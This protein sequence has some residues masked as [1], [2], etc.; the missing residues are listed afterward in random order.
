MDQRSDPRL[1]QRPLQGLAAGAAHDIEMPDRLGPFGNMRQDQTRSGEP[2]PIA[3][4]HGPAP[5]VPFVE[6][7]E[8]DAQDRRLQRVET[9][10]VTLHLIDVFF[11]RAVVAQHA[12]AVGEF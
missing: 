11:A 4:R 3:F 12:K 9:A 6:P 8:L 10:V 7:R 5:S 1:R 2:L